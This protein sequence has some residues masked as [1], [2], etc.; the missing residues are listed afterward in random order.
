MTFLNKINLIVKKRLQNAAAFPIF[1]FDHYCGLVTVFVCNVTAVC[2]SILPFIEAPV[3]ML[4][5]VAPK[6]I[7]SKW[8]VVPRVNLLQFAKNIFCLRTAGQC[9]I[10]S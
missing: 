2:A 5:P 10:Y 6:I 1:Y 8:L 4:I 7:P 9:N 3:C